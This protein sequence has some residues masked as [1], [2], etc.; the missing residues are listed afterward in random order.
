MIT[1]KV[2]IIGI[3]ILLLSS[4]L[5]VLFF[6]SLENRAYP[7]TAIRI[8]CVGDSI[9]EGT[10]YSTDLQIMLGGGYAVGNFGAGGSTVL[11]ESDKPYIKQTAFL[12]AKGFLPHVVVIMLGTND[13]S[14]ANYQYIDNFAADYKKLIGEFQSLASKPEVWLVKPPPIFNNGSGLSTKDFVQGVIPRIEQVANELGL[15][16]ID[17][18]TALINHPEYFRDGVHPNGEGAKLIANVIYRAITSD[19][20]QTHNVMLESDQAAH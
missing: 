10:E 17:V 2:L 20:A 14:A 1:M 3:C 18:Y 7:L 15:P 4:F 11:L 16:L 19:N 5:I 9:T 12:K 8:A 6:E 13:A